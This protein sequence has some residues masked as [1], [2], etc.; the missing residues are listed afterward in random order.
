M[1]NAE[2]QGVTQEMLDAAYEAV[3]PFLDEMAAI[4]ALEL[5]EALEAAVGAAIA[6]RPEA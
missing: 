6:V 4:G 1:P 3:E 5:L 2:V